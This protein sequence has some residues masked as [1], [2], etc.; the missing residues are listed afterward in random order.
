MI[1]YQQNNSIKNNDLQ[2]YIIFI[3][4]SVVLSISLFY[5][6]KFLSCQNKIVDTNFIRNDENKDY[7]YILYEI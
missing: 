3:A 2:W 1:Y 4:I 5:I 6:L 7:H